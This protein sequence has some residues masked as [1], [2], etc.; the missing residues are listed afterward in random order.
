MVVAT[1]VSG[2]GTTG[3]STFGL[4]LGVLDELVKLAFFASSAAKDERTEVIICWEWVEAASLS[5]T[6]AAMAAAVFFESAAVEDGPFDSGLDCGKIF[7][8]GTTGS[9][10]SR[11]LMFAACSSCPSATCH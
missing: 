5:A 3:F 9:L 6:S 2:T 8:R 10:L 7:D 11:L 1:V 4:P